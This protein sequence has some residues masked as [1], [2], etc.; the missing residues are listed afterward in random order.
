[1]TDL[2]T[3]QIRI[4][5]LEAEVAD[6]R[7]RSLTDSGQ[8]A[9]T[10]TSGLTSAFMRFAAPAAILAGV[11]KGVQKAVEVQREFDILNASLITATG[12][13]ENAA[14]AFDA[15]TQFAATTPYDLAQATKG[16]TQLVNLGLTP[17]ERALT[18]YGN[19]ASAMGK[20][21][22]QM[23][24]AVADAATG[25]FE[26]LKEFGIKAK[27]QGDEIS[28]T[29]RGV[30]TT[31]GNSAAEIESYLMAL[32]EVEFAGAMEQR[33]DTL[34][35]A[36]SNLGDTWDGLWRTISDQGGSDLMEQGVRAVTSAIEELNDFIASGELQHYVSA[37]GDLFI[38]DFAQDV[39]ATIQFI[40]V[41]FEGESSGWVGT[42]TSAVKF[43]I[44][45]WMWLPQNLRVAVQ[46]MAVH[47]GSI[48]DY[49]RA[50]GQGLVDVMVVKFKE[51]LG[52]AKAYAKAVADA[53]NPFS[54]GY[55]L[56]GNLKSLETATSNTFAKVTGQVNAVS[57]AR[58]SSINTIF[59]ER[60]ASIASFNA[61]IAAAKQARVAFA[62]TKAAKLALGGDVLAQFKTGGSGG[63]A[64]SEAASKKA[65]A[66]ADR[67]RKA[68][69][70]ASA[71][72]EK[73]AQREAE[74]AA[75]DEQREIERQQRATERELDNDAKA[76]TTMLENLRT[77]EEL[78]NDNYENKLALLRRH[79]DESGWEYAALYQ[80][81]TNTYRKDTEELSKKR[82]ADI[83][84]LVDSLRTEEDKLERSYQKRMQIV[85]DNTEAE[86]DERADLLKRLENQNT[87]Q[88]RDLAL[89][90]SADIDALIESL[91]T[92]EELVADSYD[93]RLAIILENTEHGSAQKKD[94]MQRLDADFAASVLEGVTKEDSYAD[95]LGQVEEFYTRRMQIILENTDIT[96]NLRT[97]L[98]VKLA[99]ERTARLKEIE[100]ARWDSMLADSQTGF[101][102]LVSLTKS[103]AGEQSG[104]YKVMFASSKA[105]A[106]ADSIMKIQQGIAAASALP[107]PVNLGAIA[108]TIAATAGI[109]STIMSTKMELAGAYD[110][111]GMIPSGK[112]GLVGEYG[113]ELI[114]GPAIITG[115][116]RSAD[117]IG[118]QSVQ[119]PVTINIINKVSGAEVTANE[120]IG[121]EGR[122]VDIVV[123]KARK[124]IAKDIREGGGLVSRSIENT[125]G[126]KRGAA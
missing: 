113:P 23:I 43:M 3:L 9:E 110:K 60:D 101:D 95:K 5:S 46:L 30:T 62:E 24:E 123:D 33:M 6:R 99:E 17:S 53:F 40:T 94:L 61:Q 18:S 121:A 65:A 92:E 118:K 105:F 108:S 83:D 117:L 63:S 106:I 66:A 97:E 90:R 20:D 96:E 114:K 124:E 103:F 100:Q 54:T 27:K 74:R 109:V 41:L 89:A 85:I 50:F 8:R 26:R 2:A 82:T 67:E 59:K 112:I 88:G 84:G 79:T 25:E 104:V 7:L 11:L 55:D 73:A 34:D 38:T 44:E 28:F 77:E 47:L 68:T 87:Q 13:A 86:S 32:G 116:E 91:K 45:A 21:L 31:I 115:R 111:G 126:V 80:R 29:F 56:A 14:I 69:D 70:R 75:K 42:V 78:L 76:F 71:A 119:N 98:E 107:F 72:K 15:L 52:K 36:I 49:G 125:Y 19:T 12:S 4:Q 93:K 1:M 51:L 64:S 120:S 35:G 102:G 58:S 81:I 16:F 10:A 57:E 39:T 37:L 22:S 122:I 48:V